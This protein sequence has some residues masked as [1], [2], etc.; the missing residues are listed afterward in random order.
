MTPEQELLFLKEKEENVWKDVK[1]SFRS[2]ILQ[3]PIE[4]KRLQVSK[5]VFDRGDDYVAGLAARNPGIPIDIV[6]ESG[7]VVWTCWVPN[8]NCDCD[9][10][11]KKD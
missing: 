3:K 6:D 4:S 7:T 2:T 10:L 8:S 11:E 5:E 1:D 9:C